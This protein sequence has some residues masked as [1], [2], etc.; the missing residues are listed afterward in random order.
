MFDEIK[1]RG[2]IG[3]FSNQERLLAKWSGAKQ[4]ERLPKSIDI[5]SNAANS[6]TG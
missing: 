1:R 2:Y 3:S 4:T 5:K 6:I